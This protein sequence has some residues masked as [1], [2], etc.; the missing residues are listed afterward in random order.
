MY[1][2]LLFNKELNGRPDADVLSYVFPITMVAIA[3]FSVFFINYSHAAFIK[4]R[5]K[6]FGV[7][8]TLGMNSVEL[9]KLINIENSIISGGA[10]V[11]GMGVGTIFSRL[12]QMI[13]L[14]LLKIEDISFYLDYIPFLLTTVVFALIF[15][16]VVL[17]TYIKMRR[18]DIS[19]LLK[20]SRR[21][22]GKNYST[23]DM[24]F[25]GF[26]LIIMACSIL[27][28][29]LISNNESLNSNSIVLIIYML[30]AFSGVY[31]SL[32][33]GGNLLI[34][35]LKKKTSYY[36]NMLAITEIHY[37]F[38]QN[39]KI[40]FVL[41][42]L[43][44]M[45]IFLVASPFSLLSLSE[46]MAE[47]DKNH[48]EFVETSTENI[49]SDETLIEIIDDQ[50]VIVN[51]ELKFIFLSTNKA[52]SGIKDSKPVVSV[53]EY[54]A[55]TKNSMQVESGEAY[56]IVIDWMP[57]NNG[58]NPGSTHT[59]YSSN[60]SYEFKIKDSQKGDWITGAK[61]FP[62]NSI[63]VISEQD[64]NRIM[65]SIS[66]D[67]IGYYHMI[68]FKNWKGSDEIVANLR[69]KLDGKDFKIS[70]I[71]ES[72]ESLRK[73]Y[74]VFLFV[75]TIMGILFFVAGGSVLYFKQYTELPETKS[76]FRKLYKIGISDKEMKKVIGTE[77][78][79][80][81]FLPLIFGAY[82]GISLIYLTIYIFGGDEVVKEF[83]TNS[84]MVV[85]VYFISQG[86]FYF[87]TKN[88]YIREVVKG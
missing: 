57:G 51:K 69:Q 68:Q 20:E 41:S 24:I 45:T 74:S 80:V 14:R 65:E 85:A 50:E 39:K 83:L 52:S 67:N 11:V 7:Y 38:N 4:G 8:I 55:I 12:F 35:L 82:L 86:I 29:I 26:G 64:Y 15:I 43:S 76:T 44:T 19:S 81:F 42:I 23:K 56:N 10:L 79:V 87:I 53:K 61:S 25:G 62:T 9:R 13:I 5:N 77:L 78:K 54:N 63:I 21:K 33:N 28:L 49:I 17:V 73:A 6:E 72:F 60:N 75:S 1:S 31:F 46:S 71:I 37:K 48:I 59:L 36:K 58:I 47:M 40:I 30:F 32:S 18:T 84:V 70:S 66:E 88:K 27:L 22:E 34:H 2:T 3:L 16:S